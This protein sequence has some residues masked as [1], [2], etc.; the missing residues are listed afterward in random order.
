MKSR[1]EKTIAANINGFDLSA[2]GKKLLVSSRGSFGIVNVAPKQKMKPLA[3]VKGM[4]MTVD[5]RKEWKQ[6]FADSWRFER[7]FF[8]D[9]N[10]HGLDWNLMRQRYGKMLED[11]VTRED[12]TFVLREL[13]GELGAGHVFVGGGDVERPKPRSTGML[14]ADFVLENGAFRI[15]KIIDVSPQNIKVR[16]PL[17]EPGVRVKAGDYILAVN[18]V[19]MDTTKDVWANFQ[20]MGGKTVLLTVNAQPSMTGARD[21]AVKLLK[22]ERSLR[23]LAWVEANRRKVAD[24]TDGKVGYIYVPNTA[25]GGQ[26]ELVRQYRAQYHMR[27]LVIDERF[28]TGGQLGD[29][30][31]ELMNRPLYNYIYMRNGN[32]DPFPHISNTGPKVML[33]NGWS[34]SG[35]DALP[36]YF[37]LAKIGPVIG[38]R[39]WG[40]LVG[41]S[42]GLPLIDG[43]YV[44]CPPGRF[45]GLNGEWVVENVG[46]V[47]DILLPNNP[48]KL[49]L[50]EDQQL[51]RA[52]EEILN[53]LKQNP[54]K[55]PSLPEFPKVKRD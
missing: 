19:P 25:R 8:Y 35:G 46:V 24:A 40:G 22:N 54:P 23:E 51:N 6:L 14:G 2:D 21:V 17:R 50:G 42:Y 37:Q 32:T 34:G 27:G 5:P 10:T 26:S 16:S 12:V 31:V 53:S 11:A 20:G 15:Q 48:G 18:G 41:P 45:V 36:F 52:I 28:N 7:D 55:K 39:T 3:G 4:E 13:V 1:K 47:P 30:F 49:A 29:R 43:G 44:S 33:A 9:E 38:T